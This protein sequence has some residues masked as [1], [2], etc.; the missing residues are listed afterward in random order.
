[1]S[2]YYMI[3]FDNDSGKTEV[4]KLKGDTYE[5][6]KKDAMRQVWD[7]S[8]IVIVTEEVLDKIQK[9]TYDFKCKE[10]GA[11]LNL[12][13]TKTSKNSIF[14]IDLVNELEKDKYLDEIFIDVYQKL[15][16]HCPSCGTV[17]TSDQVD[18]MREIVKDKCKESVEIVV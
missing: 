1:M 12:Y 16:L 3:Q 6:A 10:C 2:K 14:T 15:I 5:E 18:K 8:N 13:Y 7:A 9:P 4:V 17:P 11:N